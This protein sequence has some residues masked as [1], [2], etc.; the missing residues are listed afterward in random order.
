[1]RIDFLE[2]PEMADAAEIEFIAT[3]Q[4]GGI[5]PIE[6]KSSKR[7]LAKSLQSYINKCQPHKTIKLTGTQGSSALEKEQLVLPLYYAQYVVNQHLK[8]KQ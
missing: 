1:M 5:I 8:A 3:D 2:S 6:V 4:Q 7:T